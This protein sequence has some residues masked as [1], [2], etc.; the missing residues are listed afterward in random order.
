[1]R[2][3]EKAGNDWTFVGAKFPSSAPII[4]CEVANFRMKRKIFIGIPEVQSLKKTKRA[5]WREI[6]SG[7]ID[8]QVEQA[9]KDAK[10]LK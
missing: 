5:N 9:L 8:A 2:V 3:V 4:M 1:M 10:K 7:V 6:F